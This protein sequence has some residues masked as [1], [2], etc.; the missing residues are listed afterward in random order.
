M[1]WFHDPTDDLLAAAVSGDLTAAER[2]ALDQRL[3]TDPA[4]AQRYQE[5]Q[6][7]HSLLQKTYHPLQPDSGFEQRTVNGVQRR[8]RQGP[9]KAESPWESVLFL[10]NYFRAAM[11][12]L[13]QSPIRY[14]VVALVVLGLLA[15]V[16]FPSITG[17]YKTAVR[18]REVF[19][20]INNQLAQ[21]QSGGEANLEQRPQL[22]D[23]MAK[24]TAAPVAALDAPT[25]AAQP[26]LGRNNPA[27]SSDASS[28][29]NFRAHAARQNEADDLARSDVA[30]KA[31]GGLDKDKDGANAAA[32]DTQPSRKLI[33]DATLR[34]EVN[35]FNAALD[36]IG[37]LTKDAGGYLESQNSQRGGNGKLQ[38][39]VVVK[40]LP[41]NLDGF[42][43]KLRDLGDLKNQNVST[44]DI[45]GA[46]YDLQ[47]RLENQRR[48]EASLQELLQKENGKVS[49]LLQVERE[50]GRVRGEI[51]SMQ[52]QMKLYNFQVAFATVTITL[53]EKDLNSAAAYLLKE[54]D[55]LTLLALD[56]DAAFQQA[57][58]LADSVHGEILNA[59]VNRDANNN[60]TA[61]LDAMIPPDQIE[62]FLGQVKAL[63]RVSTFTRATQRVAND[64]GDSSQP[65]DQTKTVQDKVEVNLTISANDNEPVTQQ[66]QLSVLSSGIEDQVQKLKQAAAAAQVEVKSSSFALQSD[67]QEVA[68]LTFRLP[69]DKSADFLAQLK[70]LGSVESFTLQRQDQAG[71]MDDHAPMEIALHLHSRANLVSDDNGIFAMLRNTFSEGVSAL[72]G[73]I[74]TIGVFVA[75]VL[76]WVIFLFALAWGARRIYLWYRG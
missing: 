58:K 43:L 66:A 35:D 37:A 74:G 71:V 27:V 49:D 32:P 24:A 63:G 47:A 14:A 56:V 16:T 55:Q 46:Y 12:G 39:T 45:T 17:A 60:V 69:Q 65:A 30:T 75:F 44:Q 22:Q 42:L 8:L 40:V 59:N 2:T 31:S 51:E 9:P 28:L 36:R 4:L 18:S 25:P 68:D 29:Q 19:S 3:R 38:G 41:E 70:A 20:T 15:S 5:T 61:T 23:E 73:S 7:M 1:K 48:M 33:R 13:R 52:G 62:P 76:P 64:G 34:L 10:W 72:L 54:T 6:T 50:L 53:A 21:A 67:G 11:S 26:A 57:K